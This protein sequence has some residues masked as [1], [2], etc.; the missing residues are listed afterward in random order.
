MTLRVS[1]IFNNEEINVT[2]EADQEGFPL[3]AFKGID[4]SIQLL[5]LKSEKTILSLKEKFVLA[6]FQWEVREQLS[7]VSRDGVHV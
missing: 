3:R 1:I 6:P 5:I 7:G 4:K 2:G